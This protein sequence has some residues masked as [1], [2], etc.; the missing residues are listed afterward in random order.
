MPMRSVQHYE[1]V[2]DKALEDKARKAMITF[3][4]NVGI[5]FNELDRVIKDGER[6]AA[7]WEGV[8]EVDDGQGVYFLECKHRATAVPTSLLSYLC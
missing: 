6:V 5:A 7:E 8:F 1:Q 4:N 2:R 3:M